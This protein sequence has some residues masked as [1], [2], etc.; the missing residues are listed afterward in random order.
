M[1]YKSLLGLFLLG[2]FTAGFVASFQ[3]APGYMDAD[4][5]YSGS[6]QLAMGEGF[7]D[8]FIWNYLDDPQG[9]PHPSHAYWMPLA[10]LVG[11]LGMALSGAHTFAAARLGFVLIAA[12]I[13]PL[14][15]LLAYSLSHTNWNALL[16]GAV[17]A[18]SIF[19]LPV[20][21]TTDTFGIYMV[22]GGTFFL[23]IHRLNLE[24]GQGDNS[25]AR[26]IYWLSC[27]LLI[28]FMHLARADGLIWLFAGLTAVVLSFSVARRSKPAFLIQGILLIG[29]G[30]LLIMGP[31]LVRNIV[32]FGAPLPTAAGRTLWLTNY[33]EFYSFPA[34]ILKPERWL[35]TGAL[36]ILEARLWA[37]QL[38]LTRSIAEQ[39]GIFLTPLILLGLWNLREELT[40]R[41]GIFTWVLT[42]FVMTF[43][44]PFSGARGGFF[45]SAAA[46]QPLFWAAMPI[47]LDLVIRWGVGRRDWKLERARVMFGLTVLGL[48]AILSAYTTSSR[49]FET[50]LNQT[51]WGLSEARYHQIAE[52]LDE[53]GIMQ[54]EIGMVNN[55]PGYYVAAGRSAIVIPD[56]EIARSSSAAQRYQASYLILEDNH[57]AAWSRIYEQPHDIE[58]WR[59]LASVQGAHIFRFDPED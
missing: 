16:S 28:G 29:A 32:H 48:A 41:L 13:P 23:L 12:L 43:V 2:L 35:S 44:F 10:S 27:G 30:Y 21:A 38:N 58:N 53:W 46:F 25:R 42:F 15:A 24:T 47:G 1:N 39:G 18:F 55:P 14:T 5:Y 7:W 52:A 31:W 26:G 49:V 22:L 37:A 57:P 19:Y 4:Y 17:A 45:H 54:S 20:I 51:P 11:F 3:L 59:Y 40:V 9:L 33:D 6:A 8:P 56:G 50:V 36:A 34:T